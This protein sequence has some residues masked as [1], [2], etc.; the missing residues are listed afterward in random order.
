MLGWLREHH[1]VPPLTST[2]PGTPLDVLL[3]R[4]HD[5]LV[6][7]RG[8][9][10]ATVRRYEAIARRFLQERLTVTG[11]STGVEGLCGTDVRDFLL[12]GC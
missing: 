4:Y 9:A 5:W 12:E 2:P 8:L 7:D 11:R 1:F 3:E 6:E 10:F